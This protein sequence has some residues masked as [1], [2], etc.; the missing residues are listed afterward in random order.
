MDPIFQIAPANPIRFI[1]EGESDLFLINQENKCYFQK[2]KNTDSTKL[3]I[4]SDFPDITIDIRDYNTNEIVLSLNVAE[5]PINLIGQTFKCYEVLFD[6]SLLT[7]GQYYAELTY[8]SISTDP[9]TLFSEPFDVQADHPGTMLFKYTNS[10]NNYSIIFD[11]DIEFDFRVEGTIKEFTPVSDDVI[12]NDQKRNVTLLNSVPYRSWKLYIGNAPGLPDWVLDKVNRIM[13][14]DQKNIDDVDFE[15]V[16]GEKWEQVRQVEYPFSGMSIEIMPVENVFL[17]R[18]KTGDN[19]PEGYTIVEL[20]KNYFENAAD[21]TVAGIFS[22]YSLLKHISVLNYGAAFTMNVGTTD[23]GTEIGQFEVP[24]GSGAG[25]DLTANIKKLFNAAT[26]VYITG[27]T[28]TDA[29]ILIDY[30]QYDAV[31]AQPL[32]APAPTLGKNAVIEFEETDPGEFLAAFDIV[33]GLG[34]VGGGWEGWAIMDGRNGTTDRGGKVSVGWV[35]DPLSPFYLQATPASLT[36]GFGG[37]NEVTLTVNELPEVDIPFD[38]D[39]VGRSIG[40]QE[41]MRNYPGS[42]RTGG[43]ITF[44]GGGQAHN[45]MQEYAVTVKVKKIAA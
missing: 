4:L 1:P 17:Q 36:D 33:T 8:S 3:Q 30:L 15:K 16:E 25:V 22:K 13:S 31:P 34:K 21:I 2:W 44:P 12:Y 39:G 6:F 37:E 20:V 29:D 43:V 35:N 27:L 40:S 11:T 45:N 32:P 9:V 19:P 14:V 28:G 24:T 41:T 7:D 26:T 5:I 42:N 10:E 18:I 38:Y 23:G